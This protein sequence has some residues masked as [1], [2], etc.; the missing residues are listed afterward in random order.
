MCHFHETARPP[1]YA[2]LTRPLAPAV[3]AAMAAAGLEKLYSHQ[4]A[5]VDAVLGGGHVMLCTPTASGKSLGYN[6]PALHAL[7]TDASARCLYLF[8]TKALA[9][10]QLR[11][12]RA[13][14][15]AGATSLFGVRVDTYDGDTPQAER[16]DVRAHARVIITNPD[17]LHC[18]LLPGHA[19]WAHVLA[20][21]RLIVVDEAHMYRGVFGSHVASIL[22]RLR[23]LAAMHG[24]SPSVVCCSATVGNPRDLFEGLTGIQ[25]PLVLTEDGSPHG[26]RRLLMWNPPV[27]AMPTVLPPGKG[28]PQPDDDDQEEGGASLAPSYGA[29]YGRPTAGGGDD[30][31]RQSSNIEAAVLFAELVRIGLKVIC[32]C[33]VRLGR[34]SDTARLTR[35]APQLTYRSSLSTGAQ[36]LRIG[37]R[38]HAA[39][40][41][42][43]SSGARAAGWRV[44]RWAD[45]GGAAADRGAVVR[46]AAARRERD[47]VARARCGHSVAG[48]RCDPRLPGVGGGNVAAG[49]ALR[50]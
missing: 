5:A 37:A 23:R 39:A 26:R 41:A 33:S 8:P 35:V 46:R 32:F 1:Q 31:P 40:P 11:A 30:G 36:D 15:S 14:S 49:G 29:T 48:R 45:G 13:L 3:R 25:D 18:A 9:Q 4:A 17:M 24:A 12:L 27:R 34:G 2:E 38:L 42:V 47:V 28:V 43:Q 7:A 21:L 44:P 6:L 16:A 22:R 10:D 20:S 50:T 19:E